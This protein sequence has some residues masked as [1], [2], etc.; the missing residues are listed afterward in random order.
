MQNTKSYT[1]KV[2][3]DEIYRLVRED[4]LNL[5]L[6]PGEVFTEQSISDKYN[7]SRTPSREV[8]Q[9]LKNEGLIFSVPYKSTFVTLMSLDN[10]LQLIY[11]R[12]AIE[13]MV[14][15]DLIDNM[16]ERVVAELEYYL[17]LQKILISGDS[18]KAEEF[19]ALDARFHKVWY[20][21]ISKDVV[22]EEIQKSHIHYTRFRMLDIV[23]VKHFEDIYKEHENFLA[24]IKEKNYDAIEP[25]ISRH[26][27]GGAVRLGKRIYTEY[28]DYFIEE[29][30]EEIVQEKVID[31]WMK[32]S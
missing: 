20:S 30:L 17:K 5:D 22:W 31:V 21:A 29:N 7:V 24:I 10:I 2:A 6:Q 13:T 18:F 16:D 4:I 19:Y 26:L 11:M 3:S 9:R 15:R 25:A 32:E 28:R 1:N 23:A 14:M 12:I 27:H 8:I